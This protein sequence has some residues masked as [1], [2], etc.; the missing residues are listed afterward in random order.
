MWL[1][2]THTAHGEWEW[3]CLNVIVWVLCCNP[4]QVD[5]SALIFLNFQSG[6]VPV[7]LLETTW[8]PAARRCLCI[9]SPT[10]TC[11]FWWP[12]PK[13]QRRIFR[14]L[15]H[16]QTCF[17]YV[18]LLLIL[19]ITHTDIILGPWVNCIVVHF[20]FL[21]CSQTAGLGLDLNLLHLPE[22]GGPSSRSHSQTNI[23]ADFL[24]L[25]LLWQSLYW[26]IIHLLFLKGC[27]L[28]CSTKP[29]EKCQKWHK[30]IICECFVYFHYCCID[31]GN[32]KQL[33]VC[34]SITSGCWCF[35]DW[36]KTHFTACSFFFSVW[37]TEA[38]SILTSHMVSHDQYSL[39]LPV[40]A[41][42]WLSCLIQWLAFSCWLSFLFSRCDAS[43]LTSA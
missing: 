39:Q 42:T 11:V 31:R 24:F 29:W 35:T 26:L 37:V 10:F 19:T 36:M 6:G 27:N 17:T 7:H 3:V 1:T 9:K 34:K 13:L 21:H 28:K 30:I 23:S 5:S 20:F 33:G 32:T 38:A 12:T 14:G 40:P 43:A 2:D 18:T 8:T 15:E 41:V 25:V 16:K 22:H 4:L